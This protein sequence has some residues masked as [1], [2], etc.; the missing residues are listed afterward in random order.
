MEERSPS[1]PQNILSI[2]GYDKSVP[3]LSNDDYETLYKKIPNDNRKTLYWNPHLI[4]E[5]NKETV[6][7]YYNNDNPGNYKLTIIGFDEKGNPVYYEGK[8]N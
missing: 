7:E 4:S 8:I 6:I 2:K 1:K 3:F 5:P